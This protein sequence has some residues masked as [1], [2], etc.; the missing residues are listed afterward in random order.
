[1]TKLNIYSFNYI[2]FGLLLVPKLNQIQYNPS[3]I[4]TYY[5][6]NYLKIFDYNIEIIKSMNGI[7]V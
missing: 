7:H 5:L 6:L 3:L 2:V 1:M 4:D